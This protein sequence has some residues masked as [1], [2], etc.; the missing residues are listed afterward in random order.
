MQR[1]FAASQVPRLLAALLAFAACARVPV[2]A[3]VS[4]G[5]PADVAVEIAELTG[6]TDA[7][8]AAAAMDVALKDAAGNDA[9]DA[10]DVPPVPPACD[11]TDTAGVWWNTA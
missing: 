5:E 11:A 8:V 6:A 2:E 1:N 7:G 3:S 9:A 10:P 4:T